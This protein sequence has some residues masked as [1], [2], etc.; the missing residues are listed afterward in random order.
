MKNKGQRAKWLTDTESLGIGTRDLL[1][2]QLLGDTAGGGTTAGT[3]TS[4]AAGGGGGTGAVAK[5]MSDP[6]TFHLTTGLAALCLFYTLGLALFFHMWRWWSAIPPPPPDEDPEE[7][8]D[9]DPERL[10]TDEKGGVEK[11]GWWRRK[12][13]K[14][15]NGVK[16]FGYRVSRA[17][18]VLNP[19]L[20]AGVMFGSIMMASAS[21]FGNGTA[22]KSLFTPS[23][24]LPI[25]HLRP[26]TDPL[27]IIIAL[28]LLVLV[29]WIEH[30]G[31]KGM[32]GRILLKGQGKWYVP[33]RDKVVSDLDRTVVV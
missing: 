7:D 17:F 23:S 12:G 14:K 33:K 3:T 29:G 32:I 4:T 25:R 31:A 30:L 9:D 16:R 6:A 13:T 10:Y 1:P 22:R 5:S 28:V 26:G 15:F 27:V 19:C 2:R 8:E 11:R 24:L 20:L 18:T 21:G